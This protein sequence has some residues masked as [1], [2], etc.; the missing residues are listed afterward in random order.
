MTTRERME[1][2][3]KNPT[4]NSCHRMMDPI[5]LALD[6]FDVTGKWRVREFGNQL[7]TKGDF[8]DGTPITSPAELIAVLMKRPTPLVR[9][10]TENL[11]AYA[12]G[13]RTEYFDQPA[14][15]AIARKAEADNY[16]MSSFILGVIRS[17][18]FRLKRAE[19]PVTTDDSKSGGR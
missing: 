16:K 4:C 2:H 8:Y 15:R 13:R 14:I 3:R 19:A 11:M 5:G 17:D 7:D 18:A 9:T 1:A 10:F 6:N 12:L